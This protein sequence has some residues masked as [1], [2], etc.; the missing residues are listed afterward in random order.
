MNS[1][2]KPKKRFRLHW[3]ESVGANG[4]GDHS[5]G[6]NGN[7]VNMHSKIEFRT[8][9][10]CPR[11]NF[12]KKTKNKT[13]QNKKNK[14][15]RISKK[16]CFFFYYCFQLI[17]YMQNFDGPRALKRKKEI[18]KDDQREKVKAKTKEFFSH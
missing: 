13:K 9:H 18:A 1:Q 2:K 11:E 16:Q 10:K 8:R 6:Y 7:S 12:Q 15:A 3:N 4:S 5:P 14:V 17:S